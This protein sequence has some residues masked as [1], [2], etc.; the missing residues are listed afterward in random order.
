MARTLSVLG[1][2]LALMVAGVTSAVAADAGEAAA[3]VDFRGYYI[4]DGAPA[5]IDGME[6]LAADFSGFGFVALDEDPTEGADLFAETVRQQSSARTVIVVSDG[7]LGYVSDDF[8][9]AELDQA[10]D[11]A[12]GTFD[13]SYVDGFRRFAES[14]TGSSDGGGGT[15]FLIILLGIIGLIIWAVIRSKRKREVVHDERIDVLKEEIRGELGT[16]ANEI[17]EL[18]DR[19]RVAENDQASEYFAQGSMDYAEFQEELETATTFEEIHT[20]GNKVD[21]ALWQLE[22]AEAL[23]E[24]R[25]VPPEPTP[26]PLPVPDAPAQAGKKIDLPPE[27]QD[28][29]RDRSPRI[30]PSGSSR[31]GGGFGSLGGLGAIAVILRQMQQAGPAPRRSR[32][33]FGSSR[34]GSR[35]QMPRIPWGGNSRSSSRSSSPGSSGG[36]SRSS[37]PR[38][39]SGS[40]P[41][42]R[43]RRKR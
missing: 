7:E 25:E 9:N 29:R 23:I 27:L 1:L 40:K 11:A 30:P 13:R 32:T 33:P 12:V 3:A 19:V 38:P 8:S 6:D 14:L 22:A 24:G 28:M 10:A 35:V 5:D 15:F 21:K 39:S 17:L 2:A 4:E 41:R 43:G 26:E 37:A 42:G 34:G 16:A 31:G 18:E 20:L 36:S